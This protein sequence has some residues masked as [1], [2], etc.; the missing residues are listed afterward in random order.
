MSIAYSLKSLFRDSPVGVALYEL[1]GRRICKPEFELDS[2][3]IPKRYLGF[4]GEMKPSN[5]SFSSQVAASVGE[6]DAAIAGDRF[7]A[8]AECKRHKWLDGD[9]SECIVVDWDGPDDMANPRNWPMFKKCMVAIVMALITASLYMGSALFTPAEQQLITHFNTTEVRVTLGLS[10]YVWGYG[11]ASLWFSPM[12]DNPLFR[13]RLWIYLFCQVVFCALQIPTALCNH[14][15]PFVVLRFLAG[16]MASPP[17]ATGGATYDDVFGFP[18]VTYA[19][20][21][22]SAGGVLGPCIGPLIGGALVQHNSW[23][24]AFWYLLIQAGAVLCLLLILFP[25]TSHQAILMKKARSL[26]RRTGNPNIV[27]PGDIQLKTQSTRQVLKDIFWKPIEITVREPVLALI[28]LHLGLQYALMYLF[29]ECIP[30]SYG[31]IYNFNFV[32][33]GLMYLGIISGI[34]IMGLFY[35]PYLHVYLI[36]PLKK[37]GTSDP[38]E[39][40]A[41]DPYAIFGNPAIL[42]AVLYPL[43]VL[44]YGWSSHP[45]IHW[46]P[47][48]LG[49][50]IFGGALWLAFQSY[51]S[52]L[53]N[54]YPSHL[55]ASAFASNSVARA[56]LAAA[57]P[58]FARYMYNNTAIDGY[59]VG[60]GCTILTFISFMLIPL[61]VYMRF[62]GEQIH[63][64]AVAKYG[65]G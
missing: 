47:S 55:I 25:E 20:I 28:D 58:L 29:F 59:P 41:V 32:Q 50:A 45:G 16:C 17:L 42:S 18:T 56:L 40:K 44:I 8:E 48:V 6:T 4:N 11:I 65:K 63:D 21:A 14:I 31:S 52:F 24:W 1:S 43:G 33:Q 61:P 9:S 53:A 39:S 64:R 13:G 57:F 2:Y 27:A 12:S 30:I 5:A 37:D 26:R 15:A 54:L 7:A 23:R 34:V 19:L 22:W 62:R 10:L 60:W 46:F 36:T 38:H 3:E 49:L 51:L 35:T